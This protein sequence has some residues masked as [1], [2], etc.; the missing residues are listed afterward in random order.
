M[1]NEQVYVIHLSL[2]QGSVR[3]K[4]GTQFLAL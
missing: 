3:S 1:R 2:L 4:A